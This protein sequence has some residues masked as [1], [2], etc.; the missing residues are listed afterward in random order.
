MVHG[1]A[2]R[3]SEGETGE[4]SWYAVLFTLPR[5]MVHP[6]LEAS[7]NVM[8]HGDALEGKWSGNWWIEW[9]ANTLHT[10]SEHGVSSIITADAHTSAASSRLNWRPRRFKWTR[11]F[12]RKKKSGFCA[13]VITFQTQSTYLLCVTSQ[14]AQNLNKLGSSP[15]ANFFPLNC[16]TFSVT[17]RPYQLETKATWHKQVRENEQHYIG[18]S[19][20]TCKCDADTPTQKTWQ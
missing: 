7:W 17:K 19:F 14:K 10:T 16:N 5:N 18:W 12:R 13:C 20:V 6:A 9:V 4:W 11:P 8:V 15:S 2:R 1:D 3:G